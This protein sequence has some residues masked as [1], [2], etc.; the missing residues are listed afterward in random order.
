LRQKP[1][2]VSGTYSVLARNTLTGLV[3][4]CQSNG[5]FGARLKQTGYDVLIIQGKSEKLVYLVYINDGMVTIEDAP[6]LSGKGTFATD[7][8]LRKQY[9]EEGIDSRIS[10]AAIGPAG[11]NMV[12]FVCLANDR[13]H[14]AATG[15]LGAIMG[16]KG[17]K[18][19]VAQ[20][21]RSILVSSKDWDVFFENIMQWR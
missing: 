1:L 5:F 16:S 19:I 20:G 14:I 15:G 11:E 13:G 17:L 8:W 18:A 21:N 3:A 12:R 4:A 2:P 6:R 9:G 10:V 7:L